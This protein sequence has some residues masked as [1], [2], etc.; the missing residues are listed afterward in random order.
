MHFRETEESLQAPYW[1][2]GF[3]IFLI[4]ESYKSSGAH[5]LLI[6]V[7]Q[8]PSQH[9]VPGSQQTIRVDIQDKMHFMSLPH[10]N[11]LGFF[12]RVCTLQTR[13]GYAVIKRWIRGSLLNTCKSTKHICRDKIK[14]HPESPCCDSPADLTVPYHKL[15]LLELN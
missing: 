11:Y 15:S 9:S 7:L 5:H 12:R 6:S 14:T 13:Q 3:S 4:P 2:F 1:A 10:R 8:S